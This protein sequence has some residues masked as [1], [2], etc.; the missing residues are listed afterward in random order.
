MLA[1][2]RRVGWL[3]LAA[4]VA[5]GVAARAAASPTSIPTRTALVAN[6]PFAGPALSLTEQTGLAAAWDVTTGDPGVRIAVVD[7]GVSPVG[8]VAPNLAPGYDAVDASGSTADPNG[9]GTTMAAIAAARIDNHLGIPGTCGRCTVVPV[10]AMDA[11][12]KSTR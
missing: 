9:H 8:D 11:D 6:D 7:T 10:R 12:R 1:R 3:A 2:M 5:A 4:A